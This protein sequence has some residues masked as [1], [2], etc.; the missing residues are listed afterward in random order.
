MT[1]SV[2]S[3]KAVKELKERQK[4][5]VIG[6]NGCA[7]YVWRFE[8]NTLRLFLPLVLDGPIKSWQTND[9]ANHDLLHGFFSFL[10]VSEDDHVQRPQYADTPLRITEIYRVENGI[11]I[12]CLAPGVVQGGMYIIQNLLTIEIE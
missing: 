5:F 2:K 4:K 9:A 8:E 10:S 11:V 6:E 1:L 12:D 3:N 7:V